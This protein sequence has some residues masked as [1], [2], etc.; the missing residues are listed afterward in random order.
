VPPPPPPAD[1]Y[2]TRNASH[3]I[4][5]VVPGAIGAYPAALAGYGT[6]G[7]GTPTPCATVARWCGQNRSEVAQV[8]ADCNAADPVSVEIEA[9]IDLS[10]VT[11]EIC[12]DVRPGIQ[13]MVIHKGTC[14]AP[15][16]TPASHDYIRGE[17]C[18][19]SEPANVDLGEVT[20]LRNSTP[21]DQLFVDD[22]PVLTQGIGA[23]FFLARRNPPPCDYGVSSAGNVRVPSAG[24]CPCP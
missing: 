16:F 5:D 11:C 7:P 8:M 2:D 22:T 12:L 15:A 19:L 13:D 24:D 20:C 4:Y 14:P 18:Q 23:W 9:M 1:H 10:P 6:T 3:D 21:E 17:L